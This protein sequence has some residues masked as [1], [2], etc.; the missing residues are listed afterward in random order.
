MLFKN[1]GNSVHNL[2]DNYEITI[3]HKI[4]QCCL[5]QLKLNFYQL[6]TTEK[7]ANRNRSPLT[8]LGI[9]LHNLAQSSFCIQ[10]DFLQVYSCISLCNLCRKLSMWSPGHQQWQPVAQNV[11]KM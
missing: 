7:K 2:G 1:K 5:T 9:D 11:K 8:H 6:K 3:T 4:I 10:G